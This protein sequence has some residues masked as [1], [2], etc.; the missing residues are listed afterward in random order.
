MIARRADFVKR[1]EFEKL[2]VLFY[3]DLNFKYMFVHM[4]IDSFLSI[5]RAIKTCL[6]FAGLCGFIYPLCTGL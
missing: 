3:F 2:I 1:F 4:Y 6:R 5:K